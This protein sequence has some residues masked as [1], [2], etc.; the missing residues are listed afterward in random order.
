MIGCLVC[1]VHVGQRWG[2]EMQR[3]A[4]T[5]GQ[6]GCHTTAGHDQR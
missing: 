3:V 1:K 4:W 5:E 6:W 2:P